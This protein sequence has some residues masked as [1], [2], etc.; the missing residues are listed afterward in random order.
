MVKSHSF[1]YGLA[2]KANAA[3][4]TKSK[5]SSHDAKTEI[6][7]TQTFS[8]LAPPPKNRYISL[9]IQQNKNNK[10]IRMIRPCPCH[11]KT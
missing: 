2:R 9:P 3:T 1:A 5:I 4:S 8:E 6:P 7:Y 10:S 11:C